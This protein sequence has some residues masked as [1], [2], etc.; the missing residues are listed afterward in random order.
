MFKR[1]VIAG[2]LVIMGTVPTWA[3]VYTIDPTHSSVVFS[4]THM[5]ISKV[6]GAFKEFSGFIDYNPGDMAKSRVEATIKV[7]SID[8]RDSNRNKHLQ[9]PDFLAAD[10]FPE[11]TF[12]STKVTDKGKGQLEIVGDFTMHGVTKS[13]TLD[14]EM[15]GAITD[16]RGNKRIGFS[17]HTKIDR[18]D[19][20]VKWNMALETGGLVVGHDID[21]TLGIEAVLKK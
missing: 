16:P 13:V 14:A 15:L 17:A 21:I 7:A 19:Y 20:G 6:P 12:K 8:T 4:V 5:A 10:S 11:I 2:L 3:D 18:M 1:F 9:S